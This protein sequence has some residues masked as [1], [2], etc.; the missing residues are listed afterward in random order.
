MN[1][2][3]KSVLPKAIFCAIDHVN[4]KISFQKT[5]IEVAEQLNEYPYA[6]L[7]R[8]EQLIPNQKPKTNSHLPPSD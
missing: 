7:I 3:I 6:M 8:G 5:S 4:L 2:P 1:E